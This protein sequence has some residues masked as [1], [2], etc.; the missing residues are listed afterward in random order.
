MKWGLFLDVNVEENGTAVGRYLRIKVRIDIRVPV[1]RGVTIESEEEE[2]QNRWCPLEYEFLPEFCHCCGIIGHT[3]KSCAR[4]VPL[5]ERRYGKWLRVLPAIRRFSDEIRR[6]SSSLPRAGDW[7]KD[8]ELRLRENGREGK[9]KEMGG[10]LSHGVGD[11][12][13]CGLSD[14]E[15]KM[16]NK[17]GKRD[18]QPKDH[19]GGLVHAAAHMQPGTKE[20]VEP[21]RKRG[22]RRVVPLKYLSG[23]LLILP[24]GTWWWGRSEAWNSKKRGG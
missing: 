2:D 16:I 20:M 6:V 19:D 13:K 9:M 22:K 7:R 15:E 17:E 5:G 21:L 8:K 12:G 1:M 3:Y 14:A 4:Q 23:L 24:L 18:D 10:Q 11:G